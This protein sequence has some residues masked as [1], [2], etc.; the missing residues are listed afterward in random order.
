VAND[1]KYGLLARLGTEDLHRTY[2]VGDRLEVGEEFI[3]SYG[4]G[5]DVAVPSVV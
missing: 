3:N 2:T 4:V 1:S 5:G